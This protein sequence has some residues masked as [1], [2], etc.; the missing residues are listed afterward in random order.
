[1]LEY[2]RT[3]FWLLGDRGKNRT[4]LDALKAEALYYG[5]DGPVPEIFTADVSEYYSIWSADD[6]HATGL[7][8]L[9][10]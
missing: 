10:I 3:G 8:G 4:F 5:L 2:L 9:G 7:T 6:G 1:M